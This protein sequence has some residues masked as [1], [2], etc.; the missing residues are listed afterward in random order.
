[1][2]YFLALVDG[3]IW[4]FPQVEYYPEGGTHLAATLQAQGFKRM[5]SDPN[6]YF[7]P[8]RKVYILVYVDDLMLFGSKKV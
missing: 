8:D 1:M 3:D 7:N 4:V 5:N 2:A 6:L